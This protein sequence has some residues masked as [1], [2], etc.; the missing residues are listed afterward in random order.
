[1]LQYIRTG[2]SYG[3]TKQA[4]RVSPPLPFESHMLSGCPPA[5][6]QWENSGSWF[7]FQVPRNWAYTLHWRTSLWVPRNTKRRVL[8]APA[9]RVSEARR[10]HWKKE[11]N[12]IKINTFKYRFYLE[13]HSFPP[14]SFFCC[15]IQ[16]KY[17]LK[18]DCH[19]SLVSNLCLILSPLL[20][21][22][23]GSTNNWG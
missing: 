20:L 19:V 4:V 13:L 12:K 10:I 15:W 22:D 3:Q 7:T 17:Y 18:R 9:W 11:L 21:H 8:A 16:F 5:R 2:L 6:S 23:L 1:M 14:M